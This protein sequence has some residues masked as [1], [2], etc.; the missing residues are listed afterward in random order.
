[1]LTEEQ[2]KQIEEE[3]KDFAA[4]HEVGHCAGIE[5]MLTVI[6][7]IEFRNYLSEKYLVK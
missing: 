2:K 5:F 4:M 7:E 6:G 1:M 3:F